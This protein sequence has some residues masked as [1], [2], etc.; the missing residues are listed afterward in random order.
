MKPATAAFI[1]EKQ[2]EV[3]SIVHGTISELQAT[4]SPYLQNMA[5]K[6]EQQLA[7]LNECT[8]RQQKEGE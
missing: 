2:Q 8:A 5:A 6:L 3:N 7:E 4:D 1:A